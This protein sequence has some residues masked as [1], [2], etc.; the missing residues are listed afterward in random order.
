MPKKDDSPNPESLAD[1]HDEEGWDVNRDGRMK[2]HAAPDNAVAT[3]PWV[4][5]EEH[6]T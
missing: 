5:N 2:E 6:Q 4:S 1:E 3:R